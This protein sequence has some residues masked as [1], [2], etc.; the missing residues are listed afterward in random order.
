MSEAS[1]SFRNHLR[2]R[3]AIGCVLLLGLAP[4][5]RAQPSFFI[6]PQS[7]MVAAGSDVTFSFSAW[8]YSASFWLF[9]GTNVVTGSPPPDYP[10]SGVLF[11]TN[12]QPKDAGTYSAVIGGMAPLP[13]GWTW[14]GS[15]LVTLTVLPSPPTILG[16][17]AGFTASRGLP[18][19]LSVTARGTEPLTYQWQRNGADIPFGT[20]AALTLNQVQAT[21]AGIYQVH[22]SNSLGATNSA[23]I[24]LAVG[25]VV[26][27]GM[28][29]DSLWNQMVL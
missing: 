2:P 7:Q 24:P 11:L 13:Q 18:I 17:S 8:D 3:L 25:P 19:T 16:Q 14:V 5:L 28:E 10:L 29:Q 9:N 15:D 26:K 23:E 1:P 27:W 21:D 4:A 12:V 20:Q 6:Q 22:I